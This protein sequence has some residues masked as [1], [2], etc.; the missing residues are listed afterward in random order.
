MS[1]I[2]EEYLKLVEEYKN[3]P[4]HY[5]ELNENNLKDI[6]YDDIAFY[7]ET[8][9]GACGE[10]GGV[11]I[12][13]K[14]GK[15]Y[16]TNSV[17][18]QNIFAQ[19]LEQLPKINGTKF[20]LQSVGDLPKEFDYFYLGLGNYL[21]VRDTY[22]ESF[23]QLAKGKKTIDIGGTWRDFALDILNKQKR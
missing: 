10:H 11:C 6:K 12:V 3:S 20:I 8:D 21:I 16:H 5:I 18:R 7:Q 14:N 2:N 4:Y 13:L 19:L 23:K 17:E 1:K 15:F 9:Y 22:S